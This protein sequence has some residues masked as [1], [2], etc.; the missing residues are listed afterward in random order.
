MIQIGK[1]KKPWTTVFGLMIL[2]LRCYLM[3]GTESC[4][5]H[6]IVTTLEVSNKMPP[7]SL[8]GEEEEKLQKSIL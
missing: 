7:A 5:R 6:H 8:R 1:Q 4:R 3:I 2:C